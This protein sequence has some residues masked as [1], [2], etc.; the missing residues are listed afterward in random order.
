MIIDEIWFYVAIAVLLVIAVFLFFLQSR[1]Q[2]D[3][4]ELS[5]DLA[6]AQ[7]D[8]TQIN[9]KFEQ[10]SAEKIRSNNGQFSIKHKPKRVL[11]ELAKKK[12]KLTACTAKLKKRNSKNNN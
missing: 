11:N 9:Q 1:Y 2:R 7:A 5:Q 8:L 4:F 3:A 10:L 6:K 12:R